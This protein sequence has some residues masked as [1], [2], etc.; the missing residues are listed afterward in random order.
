MDA[1]STALCFLAAYYAQKNR[2]FASGLALMVA[3]N[4]SLLALFLAPA[5]V[6]AQRRAARRTVLLLLA[7]GLAPLVIP[8][9]GAPEAFVR[10]LGMYALIVWPWRSEAAATTARSVVACWGR[11]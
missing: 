1:V 9:A 10:N 7:L 5:L 8:L 11:G 4:V 2:P 3:V 6:V